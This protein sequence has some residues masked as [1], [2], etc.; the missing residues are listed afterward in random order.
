M[1]RK[2]DV[3]LEKERKGRVKE[4]TWSVLVLVSNAKLRNIITTMLGQKT[5]VATRP[6]IP[7]IVHTRIF[8]C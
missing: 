1:L 4:E 6:R 7:R 2:I 5:S 8:L 3:L